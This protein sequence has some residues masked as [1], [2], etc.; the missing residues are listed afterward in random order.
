MC[1]RDSDIPENIELIGDCARLRQILFNLG[2]NATKFTNDGHV[3][4][5]AALNKQEGRLLLTVTDTGIGIPKDK[6]QHV[7]NSFEQADTSTTRKFGGTGLG[8]AIVKNLVELMDGQITLNSAVGLGTKFQVSLPIKWQESQA[9][10]SAP[11]LIST[12]EPSKNPLN[13][14]LVEDNRINAIVAKGFCENL[15]YLSLIHI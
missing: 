5:Q 6:H 7:F 15:G 1:I 8:L 2:G 9:A 10:H 14:L 4:I 13:V 11:N 12:T 3:L